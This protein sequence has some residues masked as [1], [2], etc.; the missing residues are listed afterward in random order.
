MQMLFLSVSLHAILSIPKA[1]LPFPWPFII[2]SYIL[3]F[4]SIDLL[5][6][7]SYS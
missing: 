5:S 3:L 4:L 7:F 6:A 2:Y 1:G